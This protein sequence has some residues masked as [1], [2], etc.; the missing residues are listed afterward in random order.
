MTEPCSEFHSY[1]NPRPDEYQEEIMYPIQQ[2]DTEPTP[3]QVDISE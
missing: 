2:A 1:S 3:T